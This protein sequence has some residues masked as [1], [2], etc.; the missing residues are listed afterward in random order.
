L[1]LYLLSCRRWSSSLGLGLNSY[2]NIVKNQD[3]DDNRLVGLYDAISL[4]ESKERFGGQKGVNLNTN[5]GTVLLEYG[6]GPGS[7]LGIGKTRIKFA[8]QRT[9]D[10]NPQSVSN[11]DYFYKGFR[12]NDRTTDSWIS[13]LTK[14]AS[15]KYEDYIGD[16]GSLIFKDGKPIITP[17]GGYSYEQNWDYTT[18]KSGSLEARENVANGIYQASRWNTR[19]TEDFVNPIAKGASEKFKEYGG[20]DLTN[21]ISKSGGYTWEPN[22]DF[23]TTN[24]G[25]LEARGDIKTYQASRWNDRTTDSWISPLTK[26]ASGKYEDYIGDVGSL[27]FKDGKPI[28]TPGGG[29]SYEQNWDYTTT[30]SGSLE[31]RGDIKTYQ[32]SRW[33]TR[34]TEDFVNPIAKGA[35]EKFKEYG[36]KDLTNEISKSGGYTWEPNYDFKTTKSGSLKAREDV[37]NGSYQVSQIKL[38]TPDYDKV[39]TSKGVTGLY[40][41]LTNTSIDTNLITNKFFFNVYDPNITPGNTW[42]TNNSTLQ[43]ANNSL[44]FTQ[45]QI[46]EAP[47]NLGKLVGSPDIINFRDN[48]IGPSSN[49]TVNSSTIMS[50]APDYKTKNIEKRVSLGDPGRTNTENGDKNVLRYSVNQ[51]GE[52][53]IFPAL[54]KLNASEFYPAEGPNHSNANNRNDLVKFSIG[55]LQN[56][57][58]CKF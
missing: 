35:S 33:N 50:L 4:G 57:G 2:F 48:L 12:W 10:R 41:S 25:S 18:T 17:G 11:A 36:G 53:L 42:P 19:T 46:I 30:K 27:I 28:I 5:G 3:K 14:G 39:I 26:G 43:R 1:I 44:T 45:T 34:T 16:V 55:I 6:G 23:K 40:S 21:E 58:K 22:Y 15:G 13:P 31:A 47:E 52:R 9:G 56:N 32:A 7:I 54:D 8:D 24:S 20:K 51:D 38:I 29:Y 37:A 49:P